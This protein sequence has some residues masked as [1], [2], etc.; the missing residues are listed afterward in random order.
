M[1]FWSFLLYFLDSYHRGI[2]L[3]TYLC[4]R[5]KLKQI[6]VNKDIIINED[7]DV[8]DE[9]IRIIRSDL[10]VYNIYLR[11]FLTIIKFKFFCETFKGHLSI[12]FTRDSQRIF[13][14]K[15][16]QSSC[17]KCVFRTK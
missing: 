15:K 13:E 10:E 8:S 6:K 2:N 11:L 3:L 14:I 17:K 7:S 4:N 5:K 9:R 12:D 1:F 16:S